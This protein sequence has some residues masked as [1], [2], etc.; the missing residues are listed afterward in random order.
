[1]MTS[2]QNRNADLA[3]ENSISNLEA[4]G[5]DE[6]RGGERK[7]FD[8]KDR[9]RK[10]AKDARKSWIDNWLANDQRLTTVS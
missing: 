9:K 3:T 8:A 7:A 2:D 6:S 4:F 1:M 10:A 5:A